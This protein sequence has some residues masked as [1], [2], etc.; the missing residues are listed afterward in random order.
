MHS[1]N[2]CVA[3]RRNGK[4][5]MKS[6]LRKIY[7]AF[8]R[9]YLR[10]YHRALE[11]VIL[12]DCETLLDVG[13]GE[14]SP[15]ASIAQKMKYSVGVDAY[16]PALEASR[17]AQVHSDHFLMNA[18]EIAERFAPDSFDCVAATDLIE[19]LEK[20]EGL[21]LLQAMETVARR[22]VVIFTPN[23]FLPQG[24]YDGNDFQIHRSGWDVEE[25]R[26]LGYRVIG[27]N[28]WKPL[29]GERALARWRPRLLWE[30]ISFLTQPVVRN[31]PQHAFQLLC[32]KDCRTQKS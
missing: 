6:T 16:A 17:R 11:K 18:L 26:Q 10:E 4:A 2:E 31:R 14:H 1:K 3:R 8:W 7:R 30:Q 23:G 32:V 19:H 9:G 25:M 13:C 29:R 5:P 27:V 15:L 24:S 28:G 22:K 12:P 21:Q 20:D